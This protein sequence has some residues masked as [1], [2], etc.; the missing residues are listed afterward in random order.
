MNAMDLLKRQHRRLDD[1][2]EKLEEAEER[3]EKARLL[4]ELAATLRVHTAIEERILYPESQV[5]FSKAAAEHERIRTT[6]AALLG[7]RVESAAF[8][9]RLAELREQFDLHVEQEEDELFPKLTKMLGEPRLELLGEQMRRL[10]A[11]LEE[12]D[13]SSRAGERSTRTRRGDKARR[14]RM[15]G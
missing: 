11:E 5:V 8:D 9:A 2:F 13:A 4:A 7:F 14:G 12:A 15:G 6:L 10:A 1:L 3:A